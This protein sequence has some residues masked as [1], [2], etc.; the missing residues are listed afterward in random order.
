MR[1]RRS[2]INIHIGLCFGLGFA[3]S[4]ECFHIYLIFITIE[5]A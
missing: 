1:K 2:G 5:I 4:K 3:I